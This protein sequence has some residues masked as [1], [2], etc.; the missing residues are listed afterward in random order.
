MK[1]ASMM[2][3]ARRYAGV[4]RSAWVL[5]VWLGL[6]TSL[7]A[8]QCRVACDIERLIWAKS[9]GSDVPLFRVVKDGKV[10]YIDA[11]GNLAIPHRFDLPSGDLANWDFMEGFAPVQNGGKWGFIDSAGALVIPAI[12]EWAG[13]FSEGRALVRLGADGP[14]YRIGFI[15]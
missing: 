12:F 13:P 2:I 9:A 8:G 14:P 7:A 11:T 15:G 1:T 4:V 5:P 10:G 6:A 3:A